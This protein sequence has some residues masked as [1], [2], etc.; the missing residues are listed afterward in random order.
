[1]RVAVSAELSAFIAARVAAFP[2]EAPGPLRCEAP[3]VAEFAALPLYLGWTE[4]IG[5]RPD[6]EVVRWSSEGAY[7]G[8]RPVQDRVW[9][10]SALVEG[11]Q[12]YPE[13]A[14]LLPERPSGAVDCP[15]R[16]HPLLASGQVLCGQCGGIGWLVQE[17]RA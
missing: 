15:C 16:T 1:V 4:T 6:G 12:R 17:S 14:A 8:A 9:M 13:L 11:A 3:F 7:A 5:I 10:L 2:A